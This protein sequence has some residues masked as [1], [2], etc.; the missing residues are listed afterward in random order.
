[1]LCKKKPFAQR[2]KTNFNKNIMA[3]LNAFIRANKGK[4]TAFVRFRLSEGR[5]IQL[6]YKS[7]ISVKVAL[8]DSKRECIS[9]KKVCRAT[10]RKQVDNAVLEMRERILQVYEANRNKIITS[11]DFA[12]MIEGK[13]KNETFALSDICECFTNFMRERTLN[14]S[15]S[16]KGHYNALR[17]CLKRF[18]LISKEIG[19]P[20]NF[21]CLQAINETD[22]IRFEAF[23]RDEYLYVPRYAKIYEIV[24]FSDL[25]KLGRP[26]QRER[27]RN[28]IHKYLKDLNVFFKW[29]VNSDIIT[30]NPMRAYKIVFEVYGTPFYLTKAERDF[31]KDF[32]LSQS[33]VLEVAR[34]CFIFQ[35]FVGCRYGDL[36]RLTKENINKGFLEYVPQKT[37]GKRANVIRVPLHDEAKKILLKYEDKERKTL[38]PL[39][40][41][42]DVQNKLIKRFFTLMGIT[43]KVMVFNSTTMQEEARPLNEVASTHL[44]RRTFIGILYK[45]IKDPCLIS[46]MSGHAPNSTA[47]ARYRSIDDEIKTETIHLL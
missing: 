40:P 12:L 22:I 36:Y 11:K 37:K 24:P 43:R 39:R 38:L 25:A 6:F 27:S 20:T 21:N 1:M 47:F 29:C 30:K 28:T 42:V 2:L 32:D 46:S 33:K 13:V 44:A 7:T 16:T 8:W 35:C 26:P 19:N 17:T 23:L 14:V 9:T 15:Q 4:D 34:D 41:W 3:T 45:Q 18:I 5:K 31:I 10:Y